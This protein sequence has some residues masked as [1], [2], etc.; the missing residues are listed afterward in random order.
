MDLPTEHG[1]LHLHLVILTPIFIIKNY[2]YYLS[3]ICVGY[4]TASKYYRLNEA[5]IRIYL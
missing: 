5:V 4:M 2:I 1:K 3:K